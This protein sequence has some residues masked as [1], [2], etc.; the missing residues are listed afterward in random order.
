MPR[1]KSAN[2]K[3]QQV[4]PN[5]KKQGI[6]H[7]LVAKAMN[8]PDSEDEPITVMIKKTKTT[9]NTSSPKKNQKT[10]MSSSLWWWHLS[11]LQHWTCCKNALYETCTFLHG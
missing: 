9:T 3:T 1:T 11:V 10:S 4:K 5:A 6:L 7:D 8:E 2:G